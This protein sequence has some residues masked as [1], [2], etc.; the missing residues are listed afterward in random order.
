MYKRSKYWAIPFVIALLAIAALMG[1]FAV[2]DVRAEATTYERLKLFTEVLS[3]VQQSY[4]EPVDDKTLI[5]D[6]INGMLKSLDP[7]SSFMTPESYKEMQVDTKG[8]FGGLGIQISMKNNALTVIAPIDDTP[9]ARA[10]I[11]AGD[12]IFKING[13]LTDKLTLQDAVNKMRGKPGTSVTITIVRPDFKEPRDF[14]LV[15]DIIVIK[16]V[17]FKMLDKSIGYI[18]IS[19]FNEKTAA[20]TDKALKQLSDEKMTALVLDLRNNPGGLLKSAIDISDM[21]LPSNHLV[22]FTK[23]RSGERVEYRTRMGTKLPQMPMVVLVNPGS[24]SA[25][26]IVSGALKDWKRAVILGEQTFGKGSVQS[27]IPL[28][29]GA[30]LRLTT[31][32]YYT[33]NGESIQN[34]GITP[35][36]VEKLKGNGS[37]KTHHV[38]REKDLSGHL[39]NE[40]KEEKGK[41]AATPEVTKGK[42]NAPDVTAPDAEP[43]DDSSVMHVTDEKDDNQLQRAIDLLKTWAIFKKLPEGAASAAPAPAQHN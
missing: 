29:D 28:S 32:K 40:Q 2:T 43:D 30:A 8:E 4:V 24:A 10:G 14:T 17:K 13:E 18:K 3:V 5:Y 33:P 12:R 6:A 1:R 37:T 22:V 21:F 38:M 25:S 16:S 41:P 36:I 39:I 19:S 20:E 31:S 23:A 26:E 42:P 35:D 27:V 9:A 15:R 7:H 34:T 11:K